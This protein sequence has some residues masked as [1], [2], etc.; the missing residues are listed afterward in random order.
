MQS[1]SRRDFLASV[2]ASTVTTTVLGVASGQTRVAL[3]PKMPPGLDI[4][5]FSKVY[6]ELKLKFEDAADL[7][8]QAGL[9]GVDSPVRPKG[10]ILPERVEEELPRY[11]DI[12]KKRGLKLPL[13][14]TAILNPSSPNAE[15]IL[16]TAKSLGVQCYRVGFVARQDNRPVKEQIAEVRS[17][18]KDLAAM[19]KEIGIGAIVQN[20]SPAGHGYLGGDLSE[21]EALLAGFDRDQIGA[22]FDIGHAFKVHREGW[23]E[24]FDRLKPHLRIAYVKDTNRQGEW[25]P[26]GEGE[27]GSLGYFQLLK[28]T[29]YHAPICL[30]VEFDWS[31]KGKDRTSGRLLEAIKEDAYKLGRVLA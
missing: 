27:V 15:K 16:R 20:H 12:L 28:A 8:A 6:Q 29:G 23:R 18:L 3:S 9:A 17:Q 21:M 25:V 31:H 19:N 14:T 7:T 4:V 1:V 10:E 2:A 24:H 11:A 13:I 22:A 26:F 5:I 30:H